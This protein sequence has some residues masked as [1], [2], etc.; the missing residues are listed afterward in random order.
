MSLLLFLWHLYTVQ[1]K[2][3]CTKR[4]ALQPKH[5]LKITINIGLCALQI[6]Y[7][8]P[9]MNIW[10]SKLKGSC[11]SKHTNVDQIPIIIVSFGKYRWV[12]VF[13]CVPVF[14]LTPNKDL[15][16]M[17]TRCPCSMEAL[18]GLQW[19]KSKSLLFSWDGEGFIT[20]Y[21]CIIKHADNLWFKN[22]ASYP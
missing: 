10:V 20:N 11:Y 14:L 15:S 18:A 3:H 8:Q 1:L 7:L 22:P 2:V 16:R 21:W 5:L 9:V 13:W 6:H 12:L 4:N 17:L 19:N